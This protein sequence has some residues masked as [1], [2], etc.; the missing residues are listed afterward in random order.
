MTFNT[1]ALSKV[2]INRLFKV[3]N[4]K[5]K[6]SFLKENTEIIT[7]MNFRILR[8]YLLYDFFQIFNEKSHYWNGHFQENSENH[9]SGALEKILEYTIVIIF[10]TQKSQF[11]LRILIHFQIHKLNQNFD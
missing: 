7:R 5:P 6:L 3:F 11:W 10:V 2:L 1:N 8:I 9:L 4:F